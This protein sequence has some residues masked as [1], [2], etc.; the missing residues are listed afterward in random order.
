VRAWILTLALLAGAANAEAASRVVQY[1]PVPAW[2]GPTPAETSAT[3]PP[4]APLRVIYSDWQTRL[5]ATG[6]EIFNAYRMKILTPEAL[7]VGNIS[8]AWNPSTDDITVHRLRI[9]R[10]GR[11]IDVLQTARFRVIERENNL[12][13][14]MLD[15]DLTAVLQV[16]GLQVGDE[17]EFAATVRRRDPTFGDRSQGAGQLPMGGVPGAFRLRLIWPKARSVTWRS[18]PDLGEPSLEDRGSERALTYELRDPKSAV[19]TDGAPLRANIRRQLQFSEFASWAQI[20]NQVWPLFDRAATLA[21]NSPVQTEIARIAASTPD[22]AARAEAALKLVQDRIRYVYVGLNDGN[23]RPA[24]ADETWTRRFGDCK[25][26]TALLLAILR[27]LGIEAQAMLVNSTGGDGTDQR[28]PTPAAF[29]HVLVRAT[30]GS[31]RYWLDGTRLGDRHLKDLAPPPSRWALPLSGGQV[32]LEAIIPVPPLH[33]QLSTVLD[34]DASAGFDVPA[35]VR[36][37]Q[38]VRGD[39][40][41]GFQTRLSALSPDDAERGLK[42]YWREQNSWVE[43]ATVGWRFD[44]AQNL[45]VLTMAGEGKPDWEGDDKEG[46]SLDIYKAGFTPPNEHRRPKEQD[47]ATP[48]LTDFPTYK[49]WTTLIRLPPETARWQWGYSAKPV[50]EHLGGVSYW[51]DASLEN[52]VVRTTMSSRVFAPEISA[53]EAQEINTRLPAFDNKISRVFQED[54][55]RRGP[56]TDPEIA[57]AELAAA[58]DPQKLAQLAGYFLS[59]QKCDT[60]IRLYDKALALNPTLGMAVGGKAQCLQSQGDVAGALRVVEAAAKGSPD[61]NFALMRAHLLIDAGRKADAVGV[62]ETVSSAH[63]KELAVLSGAAAEA[64]RISEG[65]LALADANLAVKA[66]PGDP[67]ALQLRAEVYSK[68]HRFADGLADMDEAVR[69]SPEDPVNVRGRGIMLMK[70]GRIPEALADLEEASRINPLEPSII[71][72]RARALRIGRRPDEAIALWDPY[73]AIDKSGAGLNARCWERA[74]DNRDIDQA[75][76]DCAGAIQKAPK[77]AAYWDSF[78]LVALR[79]GRLDEALKR[80]DQALALNP[81]QAPSLYARGITR[82]RAGD[83]TQGQADIAAARALDPAA[84]QELTEAGLTP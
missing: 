28:L 59:V 39:A 30:V 40:A 27:G 77:M 68:A 12:D 49:R 70:L 66:A 3:P 8:A 81:R 67:A 14:A 73:V 79:A 69:L 83:K 23:Y 48:W 45:V 46:R 6:D 26:K 4:G 21:P 52:G 20:S 1:G 10:A 43:P 42:A 55:V 63:P 24:G 25:A 71:S 7:V 84:D 58:K 72:A 22:P 65:D 19:I 37:E 35:K 64:G 18:T 36:V 34:V 75:E 78:A 82:L 80:Y 16:P 44:E 5:T 17:L 62:L 32:E 51:R 60:A 54:S 76:T 50:R 15:G 31:K 2:V 57:K 9:I 33:P 29:D 38:V 56:P 11:T 47:Q 74:V 41:I 61:P 53:A 13:Y